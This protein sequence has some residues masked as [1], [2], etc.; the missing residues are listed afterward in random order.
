MFERGEEHLSTVLLKGKR[1]R[2]REP[3]LWA[4][5][6]LCRYSQQRSVPSPGG[7]TFWGPKWT[8]QTLPCGSVGLQG[9][10]GE[11]ATSRQSCAR[12]FCSTSLPFLVTFPLFQEEVLEWLLQWSLAFA[13]FN[14]LSV[15]FQ[16][17]KY[18]NIWAAPSQGCG[19]LGALSLSAALSCW[20]A[21]SSPLGKHF[22][23]FEAY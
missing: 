1:W 4:R 13:V 8:G 6:L 17:V 7:G 11:G 19:R 15:L 5:S 20:Q 3:Q 23:L 9:A 21:N 10:C 22:L 12:I 16:K 14:D 2:E 18:G